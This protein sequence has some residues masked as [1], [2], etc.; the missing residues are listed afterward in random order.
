MSR[1][2]LGVKCHYC[3]MVLYGK[4]YHEANRIR[5]THIWA[6][7]RD[8]YKGK[9]EDSDSYNRVDANSSDYVGI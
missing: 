1:K 9:G 2:A 4:D 5:D 6:N 3:E 8:K 7:H